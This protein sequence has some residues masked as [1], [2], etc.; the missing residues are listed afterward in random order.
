MRKFEY[1]KVFNPS[2]I[3]LNELGSLGWELVSTYTILKSSIYDNDIIHI[4][5]REIN[6]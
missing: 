6:V 1:L 4:F 2:I 5:K 3:E